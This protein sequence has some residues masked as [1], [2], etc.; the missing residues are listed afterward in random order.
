[1]DDVDDVDL[2]RLL[3]IGSGIYSGLTTV[4]HPLNVIKTRQQALAAARSGDRP[5]SR[6]A[7][8]SS[9]LKTHGV[10][11]LW[12]GIVPVLAGALPARAGYILALEGSRPWLKQTSHQLGL[13]G[14]SAEAVSHGGAGLAAALTSL[15]V[16]VPADIVSQRLMVTVAGDTK[17]VLGEMSS[18]W[19]ESGLRG[20]FRGFWISAAT[21][22]RERTFGFCRPVLM[23]L[24][25]V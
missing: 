9:L 4:L 7:L 17:S 13:Q 3:M 8:V 21:G 1:M 14:P 24:L 5:A 22:L 10:R 25:D 6:Y 23:K 20:F 2:P 11:G 16:Y 18:I 19:R 15:L 12:A